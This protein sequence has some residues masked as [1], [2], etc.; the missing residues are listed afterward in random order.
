MFTIETKNTVI[1]FMWGKKRQNICTFYM[2]NTDV[3]VFFTH[4]VGPILEKSI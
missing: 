2:E 1:V 4:A 3:H